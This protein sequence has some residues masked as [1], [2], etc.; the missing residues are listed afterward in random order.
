MAKLPNILAKAAL[1]GVIDHRIALAKRAAEDA[2][3]DLTK[4]QADSRR[5]LEERKAALASLRRE[6]AELEALQADLKK[7]IATVTGNLEK[8]NFRSAQ[9][10][11]YQMHVHADELEAL[12]KGTTDA[13]LKLAYQAEAEALREW[14]GER[15]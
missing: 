13:D 7:R 6:E 11:S 12:A 8:A 10:A 4:A 2:R 9:V 5:I 1:Q 14:R 3:T 15:S